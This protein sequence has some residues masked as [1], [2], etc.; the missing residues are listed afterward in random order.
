MPCAATARANSLRSVRIG[1][2]EGADVD[3]EAGAVDEQRR[4]DD[5][6]ARAADAIRVDEVED[7][8]HRRPKPSSSDRR[9]GLHLALR[10]EERGDAFAA[11]AAEA[12][13]SS[14]IVHQLAERGC[15]RGVVAGR[16]EQS[17]FPVDDHFRDAAHGRA[18][19]RR[20]RAMGCMTASGSA[21]CHSDGIAQTS[22]PAIS[23]PASR[24]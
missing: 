19:D 11:G 5:G 3:A 6:L 4:V 15:Q 13:A 24:R 8:D 16:D 12:L 23:A 2:G 14:R 1:I 20:D 7:V 17:G 10:R 21:S 22:A 9:E 18:D